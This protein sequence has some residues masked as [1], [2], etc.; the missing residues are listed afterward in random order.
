MLKP[1]LRNAGT[2]EKRLNFGEIA[3]GRTGEQERRVRDEVKRCMPAVVKPAQFLG[4]LL[5]RRSASETVM[6]LV[7][8]DDAA[9]CRSPELLGDELQRRVSAA[10]P[11]ASA[12]GRRDAGIR[13]V[14]QRMWMVKVWRQDRNQRDER[15]VGA[16]IV[17]YEDR[18]GV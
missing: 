4:T 13:I 18:L 17:G 16:E 7:K 6:T 3:R 14:E 5:G 10:C 11:L 8:C 2:E 15:E 12:S 9:D 1:A